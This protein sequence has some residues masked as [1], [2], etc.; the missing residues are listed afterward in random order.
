MSSEQRSAIAS[1]DRLLVV[2]LSAMGDIIHGMPAIAALRRAKPD[3]QIGW[4][5]EERWAELLCARDSQRL[6]PRSELKPLA[7]WVHVA[8]FSRWRKA[9]L[10]AE[11]RREVRSCRGEVRA[12]KY[13]VALDLQ[14]AIRSALVARS[15]GAAVRIGSSQPREGPARM[16]YTHILNVR[17]THV[18]EHA[19]SLASELAGQALEYV[20]PPF[21]MDSSIEAWADHQAEMFGGKP[22]AILNPGAGW[23]AKCWPEESFGA[24]ARALAAQ[25]MAVVVNHGPG[26]E[27]LAEQVRSS[28]GGVAFPL[29]FSVGELI[30]LT[31]RARLF[32]GGDTGPMHLAAALRVPVVALFG[33]TRPERNGPFGTTNVVLRSPESVNSTTHTD[34]RD[35]GLVSIKPQAVIE[36]A[37]QLL[38]EKHG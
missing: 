33:P 5:V 13:E 8:K 7:D 32:I 20:Q 34:R 24:V 16:F 30:A 3:L 2:R 31:R 10:S 23:G 11:T 14:G 15:T 21:P 6:A 27:A 37:D 38:G 18:I 4:L 28:S 36:A 1:P 26:E 19:L 9:L 35:E 22:L 17:G 29:K 25:G 12:R